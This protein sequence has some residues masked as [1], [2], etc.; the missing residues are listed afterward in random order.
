MTPEGKKFIEGMQ[1]KWTMK[2]GT[3]TMGGKEMKAKVTMD[4]AKASGG[5]ATT[6]K[7]AQDMGKEMPKVDGL[8]TFS[9]DIVTGEG[10]MHEV[11]SMGN[12]HDHVGKWTDDKTISLV[13][14]GK[15]L[16]GKDETDTVTLVWVSPKE[17]NF[18][19]EGKSGETV[20][21]SFKGVAKK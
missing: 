17:F 11:E 20:N 18:S 12:V 21:W 4:C 6:C 2:D 9:W 13:R 3:F 14:T 7:G 10:H 16:E 1:G 15:N 19:A 5:W 8:Y